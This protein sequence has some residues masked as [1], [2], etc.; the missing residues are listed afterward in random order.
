MSMI[1][2]DGR[3]ALLTRTE[4]AEVLG[5]GPST[6]QLLADTDTTDG[7]ISAN[8][9]LLRPGVDG[10]PPHYHDG[11]AEI[12]F[13]VDGSLETLAGDRVVRLE[14]GDFLV[15]PRGMPHAFAAPE[16]AGADVL[17]IFAPGVKDRFEYFRLVDRVTRGEASPQKIFDTQDRFDNHFLDSAIWR[18]ARAASAD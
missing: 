6:I 2:V 13:L 9:T 17:I 16:G 18:Q 15:V 10:P 7:A 4:A 5:G 1:E 8:R 12:F 14:A 11:S 3:T